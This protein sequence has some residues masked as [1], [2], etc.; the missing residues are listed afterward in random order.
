M[1]SDVNLNIKKNRGR[2]KRQLTLHL[3]QIKSPSSKTL[4][5]TNAGEDVEEREPSYTVGNVSW[6]SQ[7]GKQYGDSSEN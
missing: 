2:G 3:V 4:Q 5:I 1:T 7:Y 6:Y